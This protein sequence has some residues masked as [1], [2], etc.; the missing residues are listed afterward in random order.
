MQRADHRLP[1]R[2]SCPALDCSNALSPSGCCRDGKRVNADR[3]QPL[4][5]PTFS[6][7]PQHSCSST[8]YDEPWFHT[9]TID[10]PRR[11]GTNAR[12]AHVPRHR[13][14]C[15]PSDCTLAF[16]LHQRA[17]LTLRS[18]TTDCPS[19]ILAQRRPFRHAHCS[20]ASWRHESNPHALLTLSLT[21]SLAHSLSLLHCTGVPPNLKVSSL[22]NL[23]K[24][25]HRSS[26]PYRP[27][28]VGLPKAPSFLS[29]PHSYGSGRRVLLPLLLTSDP[30]RT[31][32][33]PRQALS[34]VEFRVRFR[35]SLA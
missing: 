28:V 23:K 34:I 6:S 11:P 2:D 22:P 15:A 14:I 31:V 7:G 25:F 18:L 10:R 32:H 24:L 8:A 21:G 13:L 9:L 17:F 30:S 1:L 3:K 4:P 5:A 33:L 26:E 27:S 29:H 12:T 35:V 16:R 19:G 20:V